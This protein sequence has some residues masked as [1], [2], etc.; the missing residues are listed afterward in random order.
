MRIQ[1]K[2][3]MPPDKLYS[4]DQPP[5]LSLGQRLHAVVGQVGQGQVRQHLDGG[6]QGETR[7]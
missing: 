1:E 2:S 3:D 5:V 4:D 6:R 7:Y